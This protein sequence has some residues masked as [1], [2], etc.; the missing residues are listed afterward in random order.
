MR[1]ISQETK[2]RQSI[3]NV[4]PNNNNDNDSNID[5]NDDQKKS[6]VWKYQCT[7]YKNY[8]LWNAESFSAVIFNR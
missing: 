2:T 1:K 3:Q 5:D 8:P 6:L 7:L 4:T